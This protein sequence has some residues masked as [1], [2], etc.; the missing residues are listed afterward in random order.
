MTEAKALP[1]HD[2]YSEKLG[3][4]RLATAG[5]ITAF[6]AVQL[7]EP[8]IY[9]QV[10]AHSTARSTVQFST[11][12]AAALHL[13]SAWRMARLA[14][15]AKA[16][17]RWNKSLQGGQ[18]MDYIDGEAVG[19]LFDYFEFSMSAVMSSYSAIEAFC[20]NAIVSMASGPIVVIRGKG[21]KRQSES[22]SAE[23]VE[24]R[25]STDEKLKRIVPDLF[26]RPTPSGKQ[27]WAKYVKLKKLRDEFTH[28]K[29]ATQA[30]SHGKHHEPTALHELLDL[31]PEWIAVAGT[32]VIRY[33]YPTGEIPRWLA[34]PTWGITHSPR[35]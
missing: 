3:D 17:L 28:F 15:E 14:T 9:C 22:L 27:V 23:E 31:D 21:A 12:S 16:A 7:Q 13:N 1:A 26:S 6:N 11:P 18:S 5:W 19:P 25:V 8:H 30:R 32:D 29:K 33:F 20:N 4:W 35:T 34:N 10:S 24:R 2:N